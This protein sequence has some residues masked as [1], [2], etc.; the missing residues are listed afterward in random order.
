MLTKSILQDK[1]PISLSMGSSDIWCWW[2]FCYDG[3]FISCSSRGIFI[4]ILVINICIVEQN[5]WTYTL[6][7]SSCSCDYSLAYWLCYNNKPDSKY[8]TDKQ[9]Q[10]RTLRLREPSVYRSLFIMLKQYSFL[11]P[12]ICPL[13]SVYEQK[14]LL[15]LIL[16]YFLFHSQQ[17]LSLL[18]QGMQVQHQFHLQFLAEV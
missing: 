13:I 11:C 16:W 2:N 14:P 15:H 7:K 18:C 12:S 8:K 4:V 5:H 17:V 6:P 9:T 3:C 10:T 1:S